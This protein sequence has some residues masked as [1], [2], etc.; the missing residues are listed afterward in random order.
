MKNSKFLLLSFIFLFVQSSFLSLNAQGED[1]PVLNFLFLFGQIDV[2]PGFNIAH[3]LTAQGTY[4]ELDL[5]NEEFPISM[6]GDLEEAVAIINGSTT[7]EPS[8]YGSTAWK[9]FYFPWQ[10]NPYQYT[11]DIAYGIYKVTN[12]YNNDY[13]YIDIRDCKYR[14][15][16]SFV[17]GFY[18]PDFFIRFDDDIDIFEW[19]NT[20][21]IWNEISTGEILK[22]W[23][24]KNNGIPPTTSFFE[25][26]WANAL[27]MTNNGR[28]PRMV[29]GP[30]PTFQAT[31]Y[32]VYR[33]A[34]ATPLGHPEFFASVIATV[35]SSTYEYTDFDIS[36][37]INHA[38]IY[39]FVKAYNGSY[40]GRSNI[41]QVRGYFYKENISGE[42]DQ[43]LKFNLNQNYPNP[44]NP[45]TQIDYSITKTGLV[46]LKVYDIL[47]NEVAILVNERREPGYH[48]TT[49]DAAN[50]PSGIY[51][52]QLRTENFT[53]TK[54]MILLR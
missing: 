18:N 22:V 49:L 34:S 46:T 25:N 32:K 41:G 4:W 26:F 27:V 38:Y 40:S 14:G 20:N 10:P 33:A 51:F 21:G 43:K 35:S 48:L 54:K 52:Y 31:Y 24:I 42:D 13:F 23:E 17:P 28:N 44:F 37:S 9:G 6:D 16:T 11:D 53:D 39:Y 29:W 7:P 12:S 50:L 1:P 30:H 8:Y 2:Q 15:P 45:T 19:R 36:L 47:G 5:E 3:I